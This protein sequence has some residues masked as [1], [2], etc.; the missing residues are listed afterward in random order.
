[1]SEQNEMAERVLEYIERSFTDPSFKPIIGGDLEIVM[2]GK[3]PE[4]YVAVSDVFKAITQFANALT[5]KGRESFTPMELQLT[6]F[7]LISDVV[8]D[9]DVAPVVH[10]KWLNGRTFL[11]NAVCSNC[12]T[13]YEAYYSKY[14]YCPK[15]GAKMDGEEE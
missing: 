12:K 1:M 7:T 9:T 11:E 15:C 14:Q 5:T 6:L 13:T 10:G 4:Q 3:M 8:V 2:S